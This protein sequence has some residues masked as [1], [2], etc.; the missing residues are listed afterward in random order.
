MHLSVYVLIWLKFSVTIDISE[1]SVLILVLEHVTFTFIQGYKDSCD[2]SF[3]DFSVLTMT[4]HDLLLWWST[5]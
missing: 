4:C 3:A 2:H 1:L 5:S